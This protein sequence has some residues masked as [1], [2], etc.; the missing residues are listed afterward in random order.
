MNQFSSMDEMYN[1]MYRYINDAKVMQKTAP[2][3]GSCIAISNNL[4]KLCELIEEGNASNVSEV[5]QVPSKASKVSRLNE[6]RT[7]HSH[8]FD[9]RI[10]TKQSAEYHE[11]VTNAIAM[12][13]DYFKTKN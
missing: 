12:A 1:L 11:S 13:Q 8:V 6:M 5:S 4:A 10:V 9:G 3:F 2:N 7:K